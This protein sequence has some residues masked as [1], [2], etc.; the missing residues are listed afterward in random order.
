MLWIHNRIVIKSV[1]DI[2]MKTGNMAIIP[3]A[4]ANKAFLRS[5]VIPTARKT[6]LAKIMSNEMAMLS[7]NIFTSDPA[8]AL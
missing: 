3:A 2:H 7:E 6:P 4:S 8:S 5:L 1:P